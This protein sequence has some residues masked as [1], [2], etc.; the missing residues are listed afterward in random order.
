METITRSH[1]R[2]E[3]AVDGDAAGRALFVD[4]DGR[5][6]F[7]HTEVGEE[8]GGQGLAGRL[9]GHALD[10]TREE[11]LRAV[12]VCPYVERLARRSGSWADVVDEPSEDERA[13]VKGLAT[14]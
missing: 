11:G 14:S 10:V 4:R 6:I 8:Y 5:R 2:F 9:V 12:P 7:F 3:I 1:D 13:A